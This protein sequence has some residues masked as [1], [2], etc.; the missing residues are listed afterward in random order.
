MTWCLILGLV[1]TG[2]IPPEGI[3]GSFGSIVDVRMRRVVL[4]GE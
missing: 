3:L 1:F 2:G 4:D